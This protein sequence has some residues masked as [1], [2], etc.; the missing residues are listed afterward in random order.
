[1]TKV[2]VIYCHRNISTVKIDMNICILYLPLFLE[3]IV[4]QN[5]GIC[6]T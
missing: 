1:M 4:L 6:I 3:K 5:F 2:S